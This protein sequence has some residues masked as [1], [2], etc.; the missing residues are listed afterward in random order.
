MARIIEA[1]TQ[2]SDG[3]GNPLVGGKLYFFETGTSSPKDT[4][5]DFSETIR[6]ENPY[7]LDGEGRA[8]N[9]FGTGSYKIQLF[10]KNNVRI[11]PNESFDPVGGTDSLVP[12]EGW[13]NDI[14]YQVPAY[15]TGS[16]GE[17]YENQ[18]NDNLS[19][20]PV[21]DGGNNWAQVRFLGVWKSGTTYNTGDVVQT[22][23]GNLWKS[24][25]NGNLNND[26]ETDDG[27]NWSPAIDLLKVEAYSDVLTYSGGADIEVLRVN[28]FLDSDSYNLPLAATANSREW[29]VCGLSFDN[30]FET[31]TVFTQG[32]DVIS[33]PAGTDTSF[34]YDSNSF[35][36][37]TFK[38][39]G[40]DTWSII[41]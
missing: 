9:I 27:S 14:N 8:G 10:D 2:Y 26:P 40:V 5:S 1:L 16:D 4:Y 39:N 25:V 7:I 37:R 13:S 18:V 6:N 38:S 22:S 34:Q 24:N 31:P 36:F 11:Q 19:N 17:I 29:L 21:T 3:L 41:G 23:T 28:E 32:G 33:T 30:R 35:G 20:D 12:F 15:V